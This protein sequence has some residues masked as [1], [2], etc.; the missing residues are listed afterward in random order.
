MR[1]DF[2]NGAISEKHEV[3]VFPFNVDGCENFLDYLFVGAMY[4][5]NPLENGP[6]VSVGLSGMVGFLD[7]SA[8]IEWAT[9]TDDV[10]TTVGFIDWF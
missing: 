1:L 7:I 2:P 3:L 9:E 5:R 6:G 8:A 10:T 4:D